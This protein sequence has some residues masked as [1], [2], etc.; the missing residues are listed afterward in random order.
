MEAGRARSGFKVDCF[1]VK[2]FEVILHF[3]NLKIKIN[4]QRYGLELN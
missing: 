1:L 2:S 3:Q 4:V